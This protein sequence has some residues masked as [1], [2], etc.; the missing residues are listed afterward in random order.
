MPSER[1][2][3]GVEGLP[4]AEPDDERLVALSRAGDD[5]AFAALVRRHQDVAF[6]AAYVVLGDADA[7][8]DAA[9]EGFIAM[10]RALARFRPGQ[11]V[12]PWLLTIVGNRARNLRRGA[13]RRTAAHLRAGQA[14]DGGEPSAEEAVTRREGR[15]LV[16]DAVNALQAE[17]RAAIACRYF[18]DLSEAETAALLGVAR[19][20]VKS[21]LHRARERLRARMRES[22]VTA[23]G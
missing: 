19:G 1:G 14:W 16:L 13:G 7:A 17:D 23:D 18:L 22:G 20:T 2:T 9:Q 3:S 11:P 15:R 10:H 6:R 12:R 5:G 21:R 8:A 4:P